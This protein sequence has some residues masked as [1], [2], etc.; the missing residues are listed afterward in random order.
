MPKSHSFSKLL[1]ASISYMD[2]AS[3]VIKIKITLF[4]VFC[5]GD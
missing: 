4:K 3:D 5:L 2:I 1:L